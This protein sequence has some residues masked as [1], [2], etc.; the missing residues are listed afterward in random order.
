MI[1]KII[2]LLLLA[3]VLMAVFTCISHAGE[4]KGI[5]QETTEQI[6]RK[7]EAA[8]K[9]VGDAWLRRLQQQA[10]NGDAK[11]QYKLGTRYLKG[12]GVEKDVARAFLWYQRAAEQGYVDAERYLA[13]CHAS[14][15]GCEKN[16]AKAAEWF[17]KAAEH[18]D[19]ESQ[20][21]YGEC[22]EY[23]RGVS[24]DTE[25]AHRWYQQA[26]RQ[27]HPGAQVA[28][29]RTAPPLCLLGLPLTIW[30]IIA[31]LFLPSLIW[32]VAYII[33]LTLAEED[34]HSF[35]LAQCAGEL[36]RFQCMLLCLPFRLVQKVVTAFRKH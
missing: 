30:G 18:G 2:S 11:A 1:K 5:V 35:W 4:D 19:A 24:L 28:A 10:E 33:L 29:E 8:A 21:R 14:G 32:L 36:V 17:R 13:V 31:I 15:L 23:G 20:F 12:D 16:E 9:W 22:C 34:A 6:G 7:A 26:A 25:E 3:F 27:K